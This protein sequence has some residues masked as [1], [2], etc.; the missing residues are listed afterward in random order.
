MAQSKEVYISDHS[1]SVL[2]SHSM[3]TAANSAAYLLPSLRPNMH[4]LDIG[5]GPGSI[6]ADLAALVPEGHVIGID[7][8][9]DVIGKAR[10]MAIEHGLNNIQF[11]VG[12]AHKLVFADCSFDVV[13][14][15]QVLQHIGNPSHALREWRRV[16]KPGGLLA[17]REGDGESAAYYP[18]IM[19][20]QDFWD[21]YMKVARSRGAEPNGGRHLVAWARAAGIPRSN[22]E[23]TA[24]VWCYSNPEERAYWSGM[25]I[26]R[27][28]TSSLRSNFLDGGHATQE[29][30]DRFVQAVSCIRI[31]YR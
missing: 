19:G 4:I 29:D 18:E 17:C 21:L 24:S 8:G 25:W 15:H 9:T 10:A 5:C 27:L 14:A 11:E 30:L 13:H 31:S 23:A 28:K 3:R 20:V 26:D 12:D 6:T 16:I 7:N 22:I 1:D 2:K